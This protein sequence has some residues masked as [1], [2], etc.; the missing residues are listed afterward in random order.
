MSLAQ[1]REQRERSVSLVPGKK[2][3]LNREVSMTRGF[4]PKPRMAPK[5]TEAILD[6]QPNVNGKPQHEKAE[7][8]LVEETPQKPRVVLRNTSQSQL[9]CTSSNAFVTRQDTQSLF[10]SRIT[11]TDD[12]DAWMLD[13]SPDVLLL[14]P[15]PGAG[16]DSDD[17]FESVA[18]HTPSKRPRRRD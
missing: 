16:G 14:Q 3:S 13:S 18:F 12:D 11:E 10:G 5:P 15:G 8:I 7:V 17:E 9:N 4:K 1:E 2:R 6:S